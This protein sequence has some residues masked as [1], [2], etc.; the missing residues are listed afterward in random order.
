MDVLGHMISKAANE[1]LL[2]PLSRRVFK[3]RISM[4]VDDVVLLLRPA[5]EDIEVTMGILKLFGDATGLKLIC[6][7]VM[8]YPSDARKLIF[9]LYRLYCLVPLWIFLANTLDYLFL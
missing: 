5:A 7:K 9:Q 8:C 6:K 2:L 3:H 1:G 4:Y